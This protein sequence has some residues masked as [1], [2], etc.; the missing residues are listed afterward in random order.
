MA[1]DS[2]SFHDAHAS[3][4]VRSSAAIADRQTGVEREKSHP[5]MLLDR[6]QTTAT[7]GRAGRRTLSAL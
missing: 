6:S 2:M 5:L 7:C 4:M 3:G 1:G